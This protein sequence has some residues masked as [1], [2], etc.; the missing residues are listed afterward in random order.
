M[1]T[2]L[3]VLC[4]DATKKTVGLTMLYAFM[5]GVVSSLVYIRDENGNTHVSGTGKLGRAGLLPLIPTVG[6]TVLLYLTDPLLGF[7]WPCSCLALGFGIGVWIYESSPRK[8][9]R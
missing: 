1:A 8:F 9:V 6:C 4:G 7:L 3:A 5:G 2:A